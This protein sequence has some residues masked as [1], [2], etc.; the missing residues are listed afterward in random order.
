MIHRR[1]DVMVKNEET[2]KIV[3]MNDSPVLHSEGCAILSKIANH[4]WR[5]KYLVEVVTHA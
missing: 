3:K 1:Y 4:P 5:R 2:G